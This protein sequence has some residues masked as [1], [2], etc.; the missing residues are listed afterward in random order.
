M[1]KFFIN[2]GVFAGYADT[3]NAEIPVRTVAGVIQELIA[4]TE[5]ETGVYL[6]GFLYETRSLYKTGCPVGGETAFTYSGTLASDTEEEQQA[7]RM[8]GKKIIDHWKQKTLSIETVDADMF[9][10]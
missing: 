2:F 7:V 3:N 10:L 8:L 6:S 9:Y 1:K 5:Q 4:E